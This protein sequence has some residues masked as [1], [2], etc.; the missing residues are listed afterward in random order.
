M[1]IFPFSPRIRFNNGCFGKWGEIF[2]QYEFGDDFDWDFVSKNDLLALYTFILT[3]PTTNQNVNFFAYMHTQPPMPL[4]P[5]NKH[6]RNEVRRKLHLQTPNLP[7]LHQN[8][9]WVP[10]PNHL[11]PLPVKRRR[12]HVNPYPLPRVHKNKWNIKW[13]IVPHP[14][15]VMPMHIRHRQRPREQEQEAGVV[16]SMMGDITVCHR[17][18][19]LP[20]HYVNYRHYVMLLLI[21]ARSCLSWSYNFVVLFFRLMILRR[22]SVARYVNV[23]V[24][25]LLFDVVVVLFFVCVCSC[26]RGIKLNLLSPTPFF[27]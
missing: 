11:L 9:P 7:N 14:R 15:I 4:T 20:R 1:K 21:N 22:I 8:Q 6:N 18:V 19:A 10:P 23:N 24:C 12:R 2:L 25:V 16:V 5:P 27:Q 13:R 17:L 3:S 26:T